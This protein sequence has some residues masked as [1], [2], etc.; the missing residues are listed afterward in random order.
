MPARLSSMELSD[1]V[2]P[3]P[4]DAP[5]RRKS[6]RA[7]QKPVLYQPAP[8][9][10][11]AN[12]SGKRKRGAPVEPELEVDSMDE[13]TSSEGDESEPDEE[14]LKEQRRRAKK[15]SKPQRKPAVKK[16]K[17]AAGETTKLVMR[18]A[19]NGAKKP[20]RSKKPSAKQDVTADEG[21][22]LYGEP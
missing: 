2:T 11:V 20:S 7:I 6:G 16:P 9:T 13:Q 19:T 15:A 18:P 22:G 17:T 12:G 21:T 5:N 3:A 14:E 10:S 4:A 8:D 1:P